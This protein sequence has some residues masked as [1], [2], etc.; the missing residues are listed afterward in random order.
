MLGI[1]TNGAVSQ[2]AAGSE[3]GELYTVLS[4]D[5]IIKASKKAPNGFDFAQLAADLDSMGM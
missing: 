2:Y 3:G 1:M 5:A 4:Q